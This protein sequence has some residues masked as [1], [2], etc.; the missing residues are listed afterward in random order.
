CHASRLREHVFGT[1]AQGNS[2]R[3][4]DMPTQAWDMAPAINP[5]GMGLRQHAR[6]VRRQEGQNNSLIKVLTH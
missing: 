5:V 4:K 3:K 6:G 2:D 1:P